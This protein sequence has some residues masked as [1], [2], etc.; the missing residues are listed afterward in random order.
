M[1]TQ[2]PTSSFDITGVDVAQYGEP[3][4]ELSVASTDQLYG[5]PQ[6]E[7][8][9]EDPDW[10]ISVARRA[11]STTTQE[12]VRELEPNTEPEPQDKELERAIVR[13]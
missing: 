6:H 8:H 4:H 12:P 10:L 5:P 11:F 13:R 9:V 3:Q 7:P 1:R 2:T